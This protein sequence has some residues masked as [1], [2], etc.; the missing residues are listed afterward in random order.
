MSHLD[1]HQI[2]NSRQREVPRKGLE[3]I[4]KSMKRVEDP[5]LLTGRPIC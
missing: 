2:P 1:N 3:W 4:G 5:R